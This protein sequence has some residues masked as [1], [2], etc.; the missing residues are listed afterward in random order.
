MT[1][2]GRVWRCG[3]IGVV[4]F[5]LITGCGGGKRAVPLA[6][7]TIT[8]APEN[9]AEVTIGETSYGTTPVTIDTLP[10][11]RALIIL[12]KE[13]YRR[14]TKIAE[15]PETG[16][17][18]ITVDLEQVAGY[19]TFE[20]KPAGAEVFL[21]GAA[22]PLGKT[23][24]LSRPV[25][26][27]PH[28]YELRLRNF[29]PVTAEITVEKDYRY[30]RAY[31]LIPEKAQMSV[32]SKPSGAKIWLNDELQGSSTPAKFELTPG[33]YTVGVHTD[34]YVM[35]EQSVDLAP[36]EER[37]LQIDMK[38]GNAPE[39]MLL[40]PEGKFIMGLNQASPDE[41]PQRE[42]YLNAF[43]IDK[44]EVTNEDFKK[45]LPQHTFPSGEEKLP[46]S[47]VTFKQ[48]TEYAQ[49]VGKRLPTEEEWEKAARGADGREYPWGNDYQ[50]DNGNFDGMSERP[51]KVGSYRLGVSPY[52]CRDMAG[53]VY[54]WTSSWY[55]AYPGNTEVTTEYGQVFRVLRGGSFRS[56]R[57]GVRC[58]RRHYDKMDQP[59]DD[60]GFRCAK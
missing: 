31:D 12:T 32:L 3:L 20:S 6:K 50:K 36:N 46:V 17:V 18:Q 16:E 1:S 14:T 40:V 29:K 23:P 49:A 11:G 54:E 35:N 42:V 15:I 28:K 24:L 25:M 37:T 30:T 10:A 9:G 27:G 4:S 43:Y 39:G 2:I 22:Q 7:V 47:N 13:G 26:V 33:A 56:D 44:C 8:S 34:G 45:V 53:N 52:G 48:A 60:Y 41:R 58:A 5:V 21:D 19:I 51:Q 57:F 55:Q 59:R 38:P